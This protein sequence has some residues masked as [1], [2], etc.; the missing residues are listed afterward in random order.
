M[1]GVDAERHLDNIPAVGFRRQATSYLVG[2]EISNASD[3]GVAKK[4]YSA[5]YHLLTAALN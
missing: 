3:D 5:T 1:D 4:G 2:S